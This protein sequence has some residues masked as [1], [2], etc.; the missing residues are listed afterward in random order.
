[1]ATTTPP[2]TGESPPSGQSGEL[3]ARLREIVT[4]PLK[5]LPEAIQAVPA[6]KYALAALAVAGCVAVGAGYFEN[7]R[8]ALIGMIVGLTLMGLMVIFARVAKLG[9]KQ[10]T[11]PAIIFAWF[12]LLLFIIWGLGMTLS[13]FA[14]WPLKLSLFSSDPV[15]D[16]FAIVVPDEDA[17]AMMTP[18]HRSPFAIEIEGHARELPREGILVG[19]VKSIPSEQREEYRRL[20][21]EGE[22]LRYRVKLSEKVV[23]SIKLTYDG[24]SCK[25][26]DLD[27]EEQQVWVLKF[28]YCE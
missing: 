27:P 5:L 1:M 12:C 26:P 2:G 11:I 7:P 18:G 15:A 10:L 28:E 4:G 8:L 22:P 9:V 3:L 19:N 23:N 21:P 24:K 17:V 16:P 13:V 25:A 14:G 6:V 20:V